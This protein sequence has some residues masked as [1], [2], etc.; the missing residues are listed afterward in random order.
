[1]NIKTKK[2]ME[3]IASILGLYTIGSIATGAILWIPCIIV[4]GGP[5]E[6]NL[7]VMI[8][9]FSLIVSI[10]ISYAIHFKV[11]DDNIRDKEEPITEKP[12]DNRWEIL[13]L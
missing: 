3:T 12:V 6:G 13:D 11:D 5:D 10:T 8:Y 4:D 9:L 1:M 7:Y 2:I